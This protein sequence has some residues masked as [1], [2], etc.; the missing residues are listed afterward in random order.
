MYKRQA[1]EAFDLCDRV[2][3]LDRGKVLALGAAADL[4]QDL[5]G[6]RYLVWTTVPTHPLFASFTAEPDDVAESAP[7]ALRDLAGW[8][9]VTLELPGGPAAASA[10]L[11]TLV[12]A[13]V[14][15][16]AFERMPVSLAALIEKVVQRSRERP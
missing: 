1:E 16:A 12:A 5:A 2:A 4:A 10:F 15:V 9:P 8:Y 6:N 3:V 11:A 13:E 7:V 14:P